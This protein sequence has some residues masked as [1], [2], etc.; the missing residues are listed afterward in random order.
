MRLALRVVR[1]GG[2]A[3]HLADPDCLDLCEALRA[4]PGR[5]QRMARA[6]GAMG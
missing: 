2:A 3:L 5:M 4:P 1:D 6:L